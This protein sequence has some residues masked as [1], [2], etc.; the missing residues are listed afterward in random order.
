MTSNGENSKITKPPLDKKNT[1]I[2]NK[3][4]NE[5]NKLLAQNTL[6]APKTPVRKSL[7]HKNSL[8]SQYTISTCSCVSKKSSGGK[9]QINQYIILNQI[10]KGKF[11]KVKKIINMDTKEYFAMK[12]INK[13]LLRKRSISKN[14][15]QF[16]Q[17]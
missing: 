16:S 5:T 3:D 17:V 14:K 13:Q 12:I 11:A 6:M 15:T 2:V 8:R 9:K 1:L 4:N 7:E 10:G